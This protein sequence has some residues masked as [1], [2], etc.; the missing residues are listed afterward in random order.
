VLGLKKKKLLALV[1]GL[2]WLVVPIVP[3]YFPMVNDLWV[4]GQ[5]MDGH[6]MSWGDCYMLGLLLSPFLFVELFWRYYPFAI[7]YYVLGFL[8]YWFGWRKR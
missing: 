5:R 4:N 7:V 8:V 2:V 6:P 1:V 3:L